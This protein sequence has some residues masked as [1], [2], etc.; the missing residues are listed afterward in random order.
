MF[1]WLF[2][3]GRT[4]L[5]APFSQYVFDLFSIFFV[6]FHHVFVV[7][8]ALR[9]GFHLWPH[10]LEGLVE[11]DDVGVIHHLHDRDLLLS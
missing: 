6:S 2:F 5:K 4:I 3:S 11:L 9:S 1:L 8:V 7:Y 10:I